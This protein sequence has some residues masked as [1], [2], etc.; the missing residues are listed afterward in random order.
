MMP[1]STVAFHNIYQG[2]NEGNRLFEERD[3]AIGDDLLLPFSVLRAE[4]AEVGISVATSGVLAPEAADAFVFVDMPAPSD[5]FYRKALATGRPMYLLVLESRLV[6]PRNYDC[7]LTAP[8][9]KIFTYDDSQVDGERILKLNYAFRFPPAVPKD[10]AAKEKLC[11][12]IAGNKISRHPQELYGDRLAAIR[13]F[14]KEHPQDFDLFG[15]GWDELRLPGIPLA[16]KLNRVAW[17]RRLLAPQFP[18]WRGKVARKRDVMGRYRFALC[19]E[20]VRDIPGYITEKLFDAFFSGTVPVY[21]GADNVTDHIPEQ[22]FIDLRHFSGMEELY[23]FLVEM[24]D[25]RYLEYLEAI[26]AFLGES[27]ARAF[28]CDH[29]AAT[30]LRELQRA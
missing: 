7:D 5:P 11:V 2:L 26:E 16:G 1:V 3:A 24:S 14:E 27:R 12:M 25:E 21:R 20:N 28:T 13:W 17:L 6:H 29:F 8:F 15:F 23:R 22:C 19:Y 10:L 30:I 4:A 9:R 18:S